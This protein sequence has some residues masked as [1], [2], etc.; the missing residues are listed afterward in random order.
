VREYARVQQFA[1][2]WEFEGSPAQKYQQ[3]GNAVPLGL[4]QVIGEAVWAAAARTPGQARPG[5]VYCDNEVLLG[6]LRRSPGTRL[7][8][9]RMR[10]VKGL[11]ETREWASGT[12]QRRASIADS[13]ERWTRP[14]R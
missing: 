6:R 12:H 2:D 13:I 7:N 5:V 3:I 11:K 8:P 1:D 9:P 14:H 10:E 4:G